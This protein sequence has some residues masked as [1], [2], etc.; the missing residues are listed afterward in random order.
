MRAVALRWLACE[1]VQCFHMVLDT[2]P[3]DEEAVLLDV[4]WHA[5]SAGRLR[6]QAEAEANLA[7]RLLNENWSQ[8]PASDQDLWDRYDRLRQAIRERFT[9]LTWPPEGGSFPY[10]GYWP[11]V[12]HLSW[13]WDEL[14]MAIRNG[15]A[16]EPAVDALRRY[17]ALDSEAAYALAGTVLTSK[18]RPTSGVAELLVRFDAKRAA[19][20]LWHAALGADIRLQYEIAVALDQIEPRYLVSNILLDQIAKAGPK[21]RRLAIWLASWQTDGLLNSEIRELLDA[22]LD[23]SLQA[24]QA[25]ERQRRA[26]Q[27]LAILSDLHGQSAHRQFVQVEAFLAIC[28]PTDPKSPDGWAIWRRSGRPRVGALLWQRIRNGLRGARK[29]DDFGPQATR[30]KNWWLYG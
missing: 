5:F 14:R 29:F 16:H 25:L 9:L 15:P 8:A 30:T 26:R 20:D 27:A 18:F 21:G 24:C 23:V 3:I 1:S 19:S 10:R 7:S 2:L 12:R 17:H 22:D 13:D 11:R 4:L 6:V 28:K